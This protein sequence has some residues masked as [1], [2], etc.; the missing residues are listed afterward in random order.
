[1]PHAVQQA[2]LIVS[3]AAGISTLFLAKIGLSWSKP[4]QNEG[5]AWIGRDLKADP[6]PTPCYG[7]GAPH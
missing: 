7:L 2:Y 5:T 4:S 6:V 3:L 1:M